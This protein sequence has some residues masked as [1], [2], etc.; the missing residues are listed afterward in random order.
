MN[1]WSANVVSSRATSSWLYRFGGNATAVP[2]TC[3]APMERR[4]TGSVDVK[5]VVSTINLITKVAPLLNP[6]LANRVRRYTLH[7]ATLCQTTSTGAAACVRMDTNGRE[8][9]VAV[10]CSPP[11]ALAD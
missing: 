2:A 5:Y 10:M 6:G 11:I 8:C 3:G 1:P 7:T 4:A 9:A